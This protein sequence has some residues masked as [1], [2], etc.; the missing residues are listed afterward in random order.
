MM[1]GDDR[2]LFAEIFRGAY[3]ALQHHKKMLC[4]LA[5]A[6]DDFAGGESEHLASLDTRS[7]VI[8]QVRKE[9]QPSERI[10]RRCGVRSHTRSRYWWINSMAIERPMRPKVSQWIEP[11]RIQ[12]ATKLLG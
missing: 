2:L 7:I 4:R 11:W 12:P 9:R 10:E 6:D 1:F 5:L 8:G 3:I